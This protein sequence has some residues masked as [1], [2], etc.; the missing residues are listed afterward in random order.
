MVVWMMVAL[1]FTT[2]HLTRHSR[3]MI[4]TER[5]QDLQPLTPMSLLASHRKPCPFCPSCASHLDHL[6]FPSPLQSCVKKHP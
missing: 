6:E 2:A 3:W 5:L 4:L 1:A